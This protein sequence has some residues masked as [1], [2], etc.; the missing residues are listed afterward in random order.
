MPDDE[1]DRPLKPAHQLPGQGAHGLHPDG[2]NT[3]IG[4]GGVSLS[5]G[6]RQRI[7][8]AR[9]IIQ[10]PSVLILDEATASMD[11]RTERKIQ[12]AIDALKD[13]RTIISIAHRL[14]TLRDADMLCVIENGE[15]K[16]LGTHDCIYLSIS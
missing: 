16:E 13:G 14:S 2:Y 7:S 4:S 6:E 10:D 11:T 8:I 15:L 9:A 1:P 3:K 5:G 12:M